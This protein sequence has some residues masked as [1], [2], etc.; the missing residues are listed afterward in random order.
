MKEILRIKGIAEVHELFGFTKPKHPLVTVLPIDE[1]M[2]SFDYGDV[3]YA[4]NLFQ[5][6]LKTGIAGSFS[7]GRNAYDF[8]EGT[9]TFLKPNQTAKVE[10]SE[11]V[12]VGKGWTLI[13][14]PD[15]IRKSELGQAI[16]EY[17]FFNYEVH[18]ALHLSD[19]EKRSLTDLVKKIEEEYQKNID[20]HSQEIIIANIEMILK[21]S[22]RYYDRQFYTRSNWHKD[23][24]S[25]F[26]HVVKNYYQSGKAEEMGVLSVQYCA[27][28]LA[29][30]SNYLGDLI[31]ME[32]G[33]SAKDHIRDYVIEKA[34][35]K[36]LGANQ[37]ISEIAYSLGFEYPQSFNRLFK[38]RTGMSPSKYRRLN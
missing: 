19:D 14:H 5:I 7:Y 16:E 12:E 6:S 30:S 38:A 15:L 28:A 9:L 23:L 26:E 13:F 35:T 33:R 21:Y 8:Q 24:I 31:K 3:K 10:K 29:M 32:T 4:C 18:E 22:N 36:L 25:K 20:K 34:K 37:S 2:T 27:E 11:V 1:R 17:S